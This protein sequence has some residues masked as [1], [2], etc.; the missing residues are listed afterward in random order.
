MYM[1]HSCPPA[2]EPFVIGITGPAGSGKSRVTDYIAGHFGCKCFKA[3][4]IAQDA[5]QKGGVCH[6]LMRSLLPG[7]AFSEKG[8]LVKDR[9]W[10][11]LLGDDELRRLVNLMVHPAVGD[12]LKEQIWHAKKNGRQDYLIIECALY[13]GEDEGF[14]GLCDEVWNIHCDRD[15]RIKRLMDLRGYSRDK[16]L[17]LIATQKLME[18][19]QERLPVQIDNTGDIKKTIWYVNRQFERISRQRSPR[20]IKGGQ[21]HCLKT[22]T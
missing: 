22:R 13:E 7:D 21:K 20:E 4:T 14:A 11:Y 15:V 16:T 8:Y 5:M 10:E 18:S 2:G 9:M 6:E 1:K 17:S 12:Y 3:D 19:R